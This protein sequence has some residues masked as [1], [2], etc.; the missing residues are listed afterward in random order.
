MTLAMLAPLAALT[1]LVLCAVLPIGT[2]YGVGDPVMYVA[3][4]AYLIYRPHGHAQGGHA[5]AGYPH[6][7]PEAHATCEHEPASQQM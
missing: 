4:A 6:S 5:H 2:L 1:V 7:A 3:M